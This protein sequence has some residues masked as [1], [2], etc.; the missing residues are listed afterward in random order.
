[1]YADDTV[2]YYSAAI[3]KSVQTVVQDDMDKIALW[4]V[5][6]ELLLNE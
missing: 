6:N 5:D 1:M 3:L 2:I 4:M